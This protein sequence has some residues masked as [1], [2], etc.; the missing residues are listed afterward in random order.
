MQLLDREDSCS[1]IR[2]G[3]CIP[4]NPEGMSCPKLVVLGRISQ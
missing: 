2:L 4:G 3:D 1:V